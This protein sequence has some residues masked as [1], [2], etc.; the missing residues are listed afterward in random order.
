MKIFVASCDKNEDT[1]ELFHHCMEK[2]W[3]NHP[4]IIYKTE[5][6]KNPY[7]KTINKNEPLDKWSKGIREALQ[8]I[9]DDIVLFMID[10]IFIHNPVDVKRI[11]YIEKNLKGNIAMF[12]LEKSFDENDIETDL[13][14]FKLRQKGS[15]YQLSLMCGVWQK[16]KLIDILSTDSDPWSIEYKQDTKGYDFYINS[17]DFIL[18]WGYRTWVQKGL[19]RGKWTRSMVE[20]ADKEGIKID[21]DKRGFYV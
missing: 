11:K 5:T 21:F 20:F 14:G 4:E 3:K 12:N 1:F 19:V 17:G 8:E 15:L 9:D 7:Y 10:D 16:D 6:I 13:E 2:Y 18:D